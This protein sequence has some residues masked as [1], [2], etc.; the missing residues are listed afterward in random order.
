MRPLAGYPQSTGGKRS[1]VFPVAGP[2]SYT[3]VTA[4][5]APALSTGGQSVDVVSAGL[6]HVDHVTGGLSDSGKY[7]AEPVYDSV[8][9]VSG[10]NTPQA[11]TPKTT[12]RL[13]WF[14]VSTGAQVSG[15]TNLSAEIVR[16]KIEGPD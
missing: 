15:S 13:M 10:N 7:R 3:Q 5:T 2:S 14:L 4:G 6:K 16:L 11:S 9:G 12:F 1:S 8:S